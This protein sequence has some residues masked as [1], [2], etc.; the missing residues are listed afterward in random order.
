MSDIELKSCPFCNGKAS[1]STYYIECQCELSPKVDKHDVRFDEE[2]AR[3]LWNTRAPCEQLTQT[4]QALDKKKDEVQTL[5]MLLDDIDTLDDE[6][7]ENDAVFRKKCY[8]IQ[9]K[10]WLIADPFSK[11]TNI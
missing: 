6:A 3:I 9:Q 7:R 2:K 10:R 5:W 1:N 4:Q 11:S 8:E